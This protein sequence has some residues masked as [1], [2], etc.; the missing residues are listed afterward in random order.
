MPLSKNF[1]SIY[2][3]LYLIQLIIRY[4]INQILKQVRLITNQQNIKNYY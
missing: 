3:N 2:Q 4:F 1:K